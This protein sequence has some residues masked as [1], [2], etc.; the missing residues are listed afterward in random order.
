[1]EPLAA[2]STERTA[3]GGLCCPTQLPQL[4]I[5]EQE[6]LRG[7]SPGLCIAKILNLWLDTNKTL[8]DVEFAIGRKAVRLQTIPR[9]AVLGQL[10]HNPRGDWSWVADTLIAQL[11]P[12]KDYGPWAR[13]AV[14]SALIGALVLA[15]PESAGS[16]VD[17]AAPSGDFTMPAAAW[18]AKQM[19]LPIGKILVV[20][21]ENDGFWSL[22]H[23]GVLRTDSLA[24]RTDLRHLD[25]A[26]PELLELIL[27]CGFGPEAAIAFGDC[28]RHGSP[29]APESGILGRLQ[30][31]F[32]AYVVG[33]QRTGEIIHSFYAGGGPVLSPYAALGYGGLQD[34]RAAEGTQVP[35]LIL[36]GSSPSCDLPF[37]AAALGLTEDAAARCI[38]SR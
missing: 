15:M 9:R 35:T 14:Q 21:N 30:R 33:Q 34:Y 6:T 37:V 12:E 25:V 38:Q 27:S 17:I 4:S 32:R 26:V 36:S 20:T 2:I 16:A 22:L 18:F 8:W 3:D 7:S 1:M 29:Y 13:V 10:W 11:T 28:C 24:A 19:G 31:T 5:Q 23:Q